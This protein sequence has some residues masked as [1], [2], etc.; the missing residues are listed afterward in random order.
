MHLHDEQRGAFFG[1]DPVLHPDHRELDEVGGR[2]L[3]GRIDCGA[4]GRLAAL[5]SAA[6]DLRQPEPAAEHRFDV[7]AIARHLARFLHVARDARITCEVAVDVRLGRCPLDAEVL[8][9]PERRHAVDQAEVDRLGG[10]PLVRRDFLELAAEDFGGRR[11]VNVV[12]MLECVAQPRVAREVRHDSQLDLRVVRAHDLPAG[13]RDESLADAATLRRADRDVLQVRVVR[14]KPASDSNGLRIGGVYPP[15]LCIDHARQLVGVGRLELGDATVVE[16]QLGQREIG[17]QLL[18]H[19]LVGGG[20]A[21]GRFLADRQTLL[22]EQDLLDLLGRV[23]VERLAGRL[24]RFPFELEHLL[25]E[26][27]ALGFELARIQQHAIAF[28]LEQ[29][30][31]DRHLDRLVNA[32]ELLVRSDARVHHFVDRECAVGILG[33]IR[34][35]PVHVDFREGDA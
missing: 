7:A 4:L 14:R 1:L 32:L 15:G 33:R 3:H 5:R 22:L 23:E 25:A 35:G 12:S 19:V 17:R 31:Q 29:Y 27:V 28:H 21:A 20:L 8:R 10:A 34:R 13:R 26:L 11:A 2:A 9:E 18:Q 16:Q 6:A 24:V 30:A